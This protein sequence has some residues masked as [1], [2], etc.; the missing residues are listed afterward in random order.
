[1]SP[2][3][4]Q[5]PRQNS[6]SGCGAPSLPLVQLRNYRIHHFSQQGM[7]SASNLPGGFVPTEDV[8]TPQMQ[9]NKGVKA[10]GHGTMKLVW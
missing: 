3:R 6:G 8:I 2:P 10:T 5:D 4:A 1:M 9:E 7:G